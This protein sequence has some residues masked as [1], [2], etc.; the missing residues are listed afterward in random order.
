M[1]N[2]F[3]KM[4]SLSLMLIFALTA[5]QSKDNSKETTSKES[6]KTEEKAGDA[7]KFEGKTLNVVATSDKYVKLFDKFTEKTGAKVEF[8]SMSS[9]E[10]LS[11]AKAEGKA[12]ADVWFGGGIDAFMKAKS[13]D[14]LEKYQSEALKQIPDDYKD[15]DGYWLSKGITVVGFLANNEVLKSKNLEVPK[16]WDELADPKYKGEVIMS[17][18]SISGTNY[19]AVKGLLDKYGEEKGWDYLSKLNDNISFYGKRGKDPQE[20]TAQ[21]EFAIGIIPVDKMA[22]DTAKDNN[23]TVVYPE[24]GIAWVPE[25][26]A[27]FKD[28]ENADVAKAFVDFMLGEKAQGMIAEIDGKDSNQLIVSGIEGLDLGLPKDKLIK[29]DLST[30]GSMREEVLNRFKELAGDKASE[31]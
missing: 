3:L 20:K 8:L 14:M 15:K 27:I 22:F 7:K 1:K 19:A 31:K 10:V 11:R 30:F 13:D 6:T 4:L 21:G 23:L 25:G 26:V 5:C 16:T 2:K 18:P 9:G 28:S 12:M 17:D 24:D 29:E